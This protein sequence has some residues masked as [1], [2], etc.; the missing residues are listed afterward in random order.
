ML[1]CLLCNRIQ[2][3]ED[4]FKDGKSTE[5]SCYVMA[6]FWKLYKLTCTCVLCKI[7]KKFSL[8]VK[9]LFLSQEQLICQLKELLSEVGHKVS[10]GCGV[11]PLSPSSAQ[12]NQNC[13]I[14][15]VKEEPM[16]LL[17]DE[18]IEPSSSTSDDQGYNT[19]PSG[20]RSSMETVG[21]DKP[22]IDSTAGPSCS[23]SPAVHNKSDTMAATSTNEGG[24]FSKNSK[25][26]I[27]SKENKT[28]IIILMHVQ[29]RYQGCFIGED[30]MFIY[31]FVKGWSSLTLK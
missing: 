2:K 1:F 25:S 3:V 18:R 28:S 27:R 26:T 14:S 22:S 11:T 17:E 13:L 24:Y 29:C 23:N 19:G 20:S 10:N 12:E 16:E 15:V 30:K 5:V 9:I 31:P 4:D 21:S 8:M 6:D 7:M